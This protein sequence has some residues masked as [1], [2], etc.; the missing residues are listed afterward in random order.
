MNPTLITN[1]RFSVGLAKTYLRKALLFKRLLQSGKLLQVL[2]QKR[3]RL[4]TDN[5]GLG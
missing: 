3:I 2:K 1:L 5:M 4:S